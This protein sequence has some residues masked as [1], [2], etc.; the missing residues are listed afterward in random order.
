MRHIGILAGVSALALVAGQAGAQEPFVL[1]EIIVDGGL[2]PSEA[3]RTGA[4]VEVVEGETL[5]ALSLD[6]ATALDALPGVSF[7]SNG[8]LGSTSALRIRGL[9]ASYIGVTVDGIDVT[10]PSG[11]QTGFDFGTFI[12]PGV[13]SITVL[14]GP[15]SAVA[16]ASAVGGSVNVTTWRPETLGFSG[17]ARV[18]AGSFETYLGTLSLGYLD[19]RTELAVTLSN[20]TTDG[21]SAR[22]SDTEADGFDQTG[23]NLYF[24]H[25]FSDTLR[26]GVSAFRYDGVAAF[27]RSTTDASGEL[28]K[29]QTGARVFAEIDTGAVVHELAYSASR[30]DRLDAGGFV[31]AFLGEREKLEYQGTAEIGTTTVAFGADLIEETALVQD[32]F[33]TTESSIT[34]AG[35]FGEVQLQASDTVDLAFT[36]RYD[37]HSEFGGQ[38]SGRA[39]LAWQLAGDVTIRAAAGTGYRPPSLN[40][41]FGPFGANPNLTPEQS[42]GLELGI[43]K[44]YDRGFAKATLFYNEIDDLITFS[45]GY[46]QL[47]GTTVTQGIE[48]SGEYM[49]SDRVTLFGSYTFTDAATEGVRSIRVPRDDLLLGVSADITDALSGMVSVQHVAGLLDFTAFPATGPL[50]DFTLAN[51]S[52]SYD[53]TDTVEAYLRVDNLFDEEYQTVRGYNASDRAVYVGLRAAF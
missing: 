18:E 50:P 34:K 48:L 16:G 10:D 19:D 8:G 43:E 37:D 9:G 15:Q 7:T 3:S 21:F 17:E 29:V 45:G 39:A 36:L 27:D 44:R 49:V 12:T 26:L 40:E 41:L 24:A 25:R 20:V 6:T 13:D 5:E 52:V 53:L 46:V 38:L 31:F 1:D 14:K 22:D 2:L 32:L 33:A 23:L 42:R 30:T 35:L 28:E 51:A 4:T 47:P 11:T